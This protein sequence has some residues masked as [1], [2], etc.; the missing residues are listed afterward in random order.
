MLEFGTIYG[1]EPDEESCWV[2]LRINCGKAR[3]LVAPPNLRE[4]FNNS[5]GKSRAI[6]DKKCAG[7]K[8]LIAGLENGAFFGQVFR[9]DGDKFA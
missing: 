3:Y 2:A 1:P 4:L 7:R 5:P 9:V 8:L 6:N